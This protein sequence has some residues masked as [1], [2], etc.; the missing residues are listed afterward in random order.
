[1]TDDATP[2]GYYR[3]ENELLA[4]LLLQILLE[5]CGGDGKFRGRYEP[6]DPHA[7]YSY[8][9]A[10]YA[11]A[12]IALHELGLIEITE[13]TTRGILAKVTP[14]GRAVLDRFPAEQRRGDAPSWRPGP[15]VSP[16]LDPCLFFR[17]RD[18]GGSVPAAGAV[19][20]RVTPGFWG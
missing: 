16:E 18:R 12:M 10:S 5:Y 14:G 9:Q 3:G 7:R 2:P 8:E 17:Q 6:A 20:N 4:A 13:Q 11:D 15:L 19:L 1:M